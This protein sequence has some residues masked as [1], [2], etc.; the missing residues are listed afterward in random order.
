VID[1]QSTAPLA[2]G[3]TTYTPDPNAPPGTMETIGR[4]N[5]LG[6]TS[7]GAPGNLMGWCEALARFGTFPLAD[8]MEPAIRH[9]SR[10]FRVTPY[11]CEC[12]ADCAA[13]M[14]RDPEIA[15]L[16]L[17]GGAPITPGTRLVTGAYAETLR[18]IAKEGPSCCMA[19]RSA[20]TTPITWRNRRLHLTMEDL[21]T[22]RTVTR[23]ALRGTY[24]GFEIVGPP[25][26]SSGPLHI[27]QM[28][29]I[30]EHYDIGALGFGRRTLHLLAEVLKIAFADRAAATAD[31]AFVQVPV[32]KLLS[33]SYAAERR[34]RID[35]PVPKPGAP[36]CAGRRPRTPRT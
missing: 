28:L 34:E 8:V 24:R 3:P 23:E 18:A 9:A 27:I 26:P 29:N 32:A 1:G 21:T 22:Y 15:A 2:T 4:K 7:V 16:Y 36:G 25:P 31:P 14:A 12:V 20:S 30:L 5:A 11:L 35:M 13:D 10:G 17:P 19:A 6:P 33:K